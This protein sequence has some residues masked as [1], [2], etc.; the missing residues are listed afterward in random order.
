M[1]RI[2]FGRLDPVRIR[3]GMR[4][5]IWIQVGKN[6]PQKLKKCS[7]LSSVADPDPGSGIRDW[8]LLDPWI[9]DPKAIFLR[10]F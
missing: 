8:V 9:R 5:R 2:D 10:A 1:I 6:D 7:P 4:I 3:I